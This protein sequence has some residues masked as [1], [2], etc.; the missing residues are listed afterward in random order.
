MQLK[1]LELFGFKS[2]ADRTRFDFEPGVTIIVGPNGCGKSNV[3]DSMKWILGEQSAK[4]L[5]GTEML[6]VIFN[7]SRTRKALGFAEASLTFANTKG[8]IHPDLD[9]ICVTRRLH[10]DGESEY[11]INRKSCRL[12]DIRELFMDTGVGLR[13]YSIIEQGKIDAFLQASPIDRRLVFEEAAG[14][15]KYK[16]RKKEAIRKLERVGY[17]LEMISVNIT[18]LDKQLRSLKVQAGRARSFKEA[19]ERL[20]KLR[21]ALS[22][23][24]YHRCQQDCI[25]TSGEL[26]LAE[27]SLADVKAAIAVKDAEIASVDDSLRERESMIMEKSSQLSALENDYNLSNERIRA[28][29]RTIE[30]IKAE[31]IR[32]EERRAECQRRI[33]ES[34][35][36]MDGIEL[37]RSEAEERSASVARRV[38]I[39][40]SD[41][42][43]VS[44]SL[45]SAQEGIAEGKAKIFAVNSDK[46]RITG[47]LEKLKARF[48]DLDR[49][50]A[51]LE[52]ER[53]GVAKQAD[54][55]QARCEMLT[56][57]IASC[58]EK[59]DV[60]KLE[61][62]SLE[63]REAAMSEELSQRKQAVADLE[64]T[65]LK[66]SSRTEV[67][68][69]YRD[70]LEGVS[71]GARQVLEEAKRGN[72]ALAGVRGLLVDAIKADEKFARAVEEALGGDNCD[73][74]VSDFASAEA[75]VAFLKESK[76]GRG[77]FVPVAPP[78][79]LPDDGLS[80]ANYPGVL[81]RAVDFVEAPADVKPIL[82]RRLGWTLVVEN[83]AA[84]A[85]LRDVLKGYDFVSLQGEV[86]KSDGTLSGGT[87]TMGRI[88]HAAEIAR[89]KVRLESVAAEL[90]SARADL[91]K[92]KA[93]AAEVRARMQ[94]ARHQ[95]YDAGSQLANAQEN[96]K[97]SD[98][99]LGEFR[100]QLEIIEGDIAAVDSEAGLNRAESAD[101]A[102][103]ADA[104]QKEEDRVKAEMNALDAEISSLSGELDGKKSGLA[105]ANT[106]AAMAKMEIGNLREK[107]AALRKD[108]S[109]R[110]A[111]LSDLGE[112]MK[113]K[114]GERIALGDENAALGEKAA[115]LMREIADAKQGMEYLRGIRDDLEQEKSLK[116]S[117]QK[118]KKAEEEKLA[119]SV[120]SLKIDEERLKMLREN[121][122]K[123]AAEE[124]EVDVADLYSEFDDERDDWEAI[125][126]EAAELRQRIKNL[127]SVNESA[128]EEFETVSQR[129]NYLSAQRDDLVAA[130]E[131]ITSI[132][133]QIDKKSKVMFVETFET[134]R[135]NFKI[136]FK[137]L[138]NGGKADVIIVDEN[139]M[140]ES[141][142][143]IVA[144]PGDKKPQSITLLSGGEKVMTCIALLFAVF[145]SKP[146]PFCILD[147]VDAALDERNIDRFVNMLGDFLKGSQFIIISHNKRTMMVGDRIFGIT[148]QEAGVSKKVSLEITEAKEMVDRI[149]KGA[150]PAMVADLGIEQPA[151]K[152]EAAAPEKAEQPAEK[153]EPAAPEP[154]EQP[155]EVAADK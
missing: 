46:A 63:S 51:A 100:G 93:E 41:I 14:I 28:N 45:A 57:E 48:T 99:A 3:V 55:A 147:E 76:K 96:C 69:G 110:K 38:E 80:L 5:R 151:D 2:F 13:A 44:A 10:R 131:Q 107:L 70:R 20:R 60:L 53:D 103:R 75:A 115:A 141:P 153:A 26:V 78:A 155:A 152:T 79:D 117:Q 146:S 62:A 84:A 65:R 139:D 109:E 94:E 11:M 82:D 77:T 125:N 22:L 12:K 72:P 35:S 124:L 134:I 108:I 42:A 74:L 81:G 71:E 27:N 67:L 126:G 39:L 49:K 138:F 92:L 7:G 119:S 16:A 140:L 89:L 9:E 88:S 137:Q 64:E 33:E 87:A 133:R 1:K 154:A 122:L 37:K 23:H 85:G 40:E 21:V 58:T 50:K 43:R 31:E 66:L 149:S 4:S 15:S 61:L 17:N 132:I 30:A 52:S 105:S 150:E 127:G 97:E 8:I 135:E 34:G 18:E 29:Q 36:D 32:I 59:F 86:L 145:K 116:V 47:D 19:S 95:C 68:E 123:R 143:E 91:E 148:M 130:K 113:R 120:Q 121:I 54:K 112:E 25:G 104:L 90:A 73:V 98:N 102:L 106:D 142:I 128:I 129:F 24:E 83:L 111:A 56:E 136:I 144:Q 6:D 114:D 101:L 118:E